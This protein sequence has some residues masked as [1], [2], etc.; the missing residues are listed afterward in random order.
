[1]PVQ[2]GRR[3]GFSLPE[4]RPA[5]SPEICSSHCT[6]HPHC[7][8]WSW[9]QCNVASSGACT[10]KNL[11]GEVEP[12]SDPAHGHSC[13]ATRAFSAARSP[14]IP[15]RGNFTPWGYIAMPYHRDRHRSGILRMHDSLNGLG[16]YA[17]GNADSNPHASQ[18]AATAF[19]GAGE[20]ITADDFEAAGVERT[21]PVHTNGRIAVAHSYNDVTIETEFFLVTESVIAGRLIVTKSASSAAAAADRD[22]FSINLHVDNGG[23]NG[24]AEAWVGAP[25]GIG[26]CP[27]LQSRGLL[28]GGWSIAVLTGDDARMKLTSQNFYPSLAALRQGLKSGA[29]ARGNFTAVTAELFLSNRFSVKDLASGGSVN[30]TFVFARDGPVGVGGGAVR[31][32]T[33][34]TEAAASG[35]IDNQWN[36]HAD[37][38]KNFWETAVKLEGDWPETWKR[39]LVYDFNT[40]RANIRPAVGVFKHPWDAMQVH[41]PRIVVAESSMDAMTLSYADVALAKDMLFGLYADTAARG[42]PQVPCQTEDGTTNMECAD[43]NA[44]GTP[45]SWGLPLWTVRS[46]F[47]RDGDREWLAKMY[48]LL[49]GYLDFWLTNRTDDQGYQICKCSWESG[50]CNPAGLAPLVLAVR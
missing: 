37:A 20:L 3:R 40:V 24:S 17:N 35:E 6:A 8:A 48:P 27:T 16:L 36:R 28:E 26:C 14:A 9:T 4:P 23:N 25:A 19:I 47:S 31:A 44:A 39:G 10:L 12:D 15:L 42:Q 5:A 11:V 30:A 33:H 34:I 7:V 18:Y 2:C 29:A 50:T 13:T 32:A 49:A 22:Y 45:P 21:S 43:G 38:D 1:M 41:N 46:I